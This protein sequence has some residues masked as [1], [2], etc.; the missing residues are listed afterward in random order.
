MLTHLAAATLTVTLASS[1]IAQPA[2]TP[3]P[4]S[5]SKSTPIPQA[6]KPAPNVS[7]AYPHPLITEVLFAVPTG[8]DGDANGDGARSATGDEFI[9][10]VNPHDKAINIKGYTITDSREVKYEDDPAAKPGPDGKKP[11]KAKVL[12]PQLE[13]TFPDLVLQPGEVALLFNGY[14]QKWAQPVGDKAKAGSRVAK[15]QNA[16]IFSAGAESRFIALNN[17]G[18]CIQLF[19]PGVRESID[20]LWW[21]KGDE[22]G[23]DASTLIEEL[24]EGSGSV[25]RV[26]LTTQW[27]ASTD[28]TG[29]LKGKFSPGSVEL[30]AMPAKDTSRPGVKPNS[31]PVPKTAEKPS[32]APNTPTR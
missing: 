27:L 13:F 8:S 3:N 28:L 29:S 30:P 14:E 20:C 23:R 17:E 9:E 2:T 7:I 19:A 12:R 5:K 16:Y 1:L 26:G 32:T 31:K 18:D 4:N 11:K 10:L 6:D 25:H 21:G 24:P 22:N 15:F